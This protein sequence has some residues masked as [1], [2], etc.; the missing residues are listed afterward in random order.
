MNPPMCLD[1]QVTEPRS[2]EVSKPGEAS[3]GVANRNHL[4]CLSVVF[5]LFAAYHFLTADQEVA[6]N[7]PNLNQLQNTKA[8]KDLRLTRKTRGVAE[9]RQWP[10]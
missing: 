6:T 4:D 2:L 3:A 5:V 1:L 10:A 9:R 7:S 8:T